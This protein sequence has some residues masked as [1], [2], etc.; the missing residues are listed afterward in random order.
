MEV[1]ANASPLMRWSAV[2]AVCGGLILIAA[3]GFLATVLWRHTPI[4]GQFSDYS[5][6]PPALIACFVIASAIVLVASTFAWHIANHRLLMAVKRRAQL[7]ILAA[8]SGWL[9][10]GAA[11]FLLARR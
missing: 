3:I 7:A 8:G 1:S 2:L 11:V 4:D 9:L 5:I 6:V 10:V